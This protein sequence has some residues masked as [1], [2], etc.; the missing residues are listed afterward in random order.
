MIQLDT[1]V[2]CD[3][4]YVTTKSVEKY[5]L[6]VFYLQTCPFDL[7][8]T[9]SKNTKS[10]GRAGTVW[11]TAFCQVTQVR[12]LSLPPFVLSHPTGVFS[13]SGLIP[14]H[15]LPPSLSSHPPAS[16][17]SQDRPFST[18]KPWLHS[19]AIS[20]PPSEQ[21]PSASLSLSSRGCRPRFPFEDVIL[22]KLRDISGI[23]LNVFSM[24]TA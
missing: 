14:L 23:I 13:L 5:V 6:C 22:E 16:L 21:E 3:W 4:L 9:T 11:F 18:P 2:L 7:N 17:A 15:H 8:M 20:P 10:L 12:V 19:W 24:S 1:H